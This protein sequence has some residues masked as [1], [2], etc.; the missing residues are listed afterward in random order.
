MKTL[1]KVFGFVFFFLRRRQQEVEIVE[2]RL[3]QCVVSTPSVSV[4]LPVSVGQKVS[5]LTKRTE[6]WHTAFVVSVGKGWLYLHPDPYHQ[7]RANCFRRKNDLI[8]I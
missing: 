5:F 2:R 1:N 7:K 3:E 4:S 6:R 8:R